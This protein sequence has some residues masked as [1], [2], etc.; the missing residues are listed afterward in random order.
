MLAGGVTNCSFSR[1]VVAVLPLPLFSR[2]KLLVINSFLD[3]ESANDPPA[4]LLLDGDFN[5]LWLG[6][7]PFRKRDR[8]DAVLVR[9]ADFARINPAGEGDAATEFATETLGAFPIFS[10]A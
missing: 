5:F 4:S 2:T 8:Q 1:R 6:F 10:F 9:G 3:F 7:F